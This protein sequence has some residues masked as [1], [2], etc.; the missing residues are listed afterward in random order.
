MY[1]IS[2]DYLTALK[3]Q[4][5][6]Y[7][8]RGT[9]NGTAFDEDDIS[10]LTVSNRCADD[11]EVSI[12]SVYMAEL[13]INFLKS[14]G[15]AWKFSKGWEITIEEGLWI[16]SLEE[17]QYVPGGVYFVEEVQ[18]TKEGIQVTAYDA[19]A[20]FEKSINGLSTQ[21]NLLPSLLEQVC[22]RCGVELANESFEGFPNSST[23]FSLDPE[24]DIENC[25]DLL[26]W[27]AQTMAAY[28]TIN[29]DGE[30]ELRMYK[31]TNDYEDYI[32]ADARADSY[33]FNNYV[34]RYTG[35]M[36]TDREK[37]R[38]K[39]YSEEVDNG[40]T[41][42]LGVNPFMQKLTDQRLQAVCM[43]ILDKMQDIEY[44]PFSI[45]C[46][47]TFAYD[48]GDIINFDDLETANPRIGCIM[49]WDYS[50]NNS[51]RFEGLGSDPAVASAKSKTDKNLS[52]LMS[53]VEASKEYLYSFNNSE[54]ILI[55]EIWHT[56]L[57]QRFGTVSAT[58]ALFHGEILCEALG[59]TVV[60]VRYLLD[61]EIV[62][63]FPVETWKQGKHILTLM[64]PITTN[65]D[66]YY[67]W[68][69]QLRSLSASVQID[70]GNA[71]GIIKGQG[72]VASDVWNGYID[73]DETYTLLN[74][75]DDAEVIRVSDT[76]TASTQVPISG[77][78][79]S[80]SYGLLSTSED[81]SIVDF[82]DGYAFNQDFKNKMTWDESA[83]NNWDYS[84]TFYVWG[85]DVD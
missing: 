42:N 67:N 21:N 76:A 18:T 15:I 53:E 36:V 59:D 82:I 32:D 3:Y 13:R 55:G 37:Q 72:L 79:Y 12:G 48:L 46:L 14:L 8:L 17:Y 39:Y 26:S 34:T 29:R 60:E 6:R 11:G 49:L 33:V 47:P 64:Y 70:A 66:N 78:N 69:V 9:I 65:S 35:I 58:W 74:S 84:E 80:E 57:S 63:R 28:A 44:T 83:L 23:A 73:I 22:N 19:M 20:K 54:D 56:V 75:L 16:E 7:K 40:L 27:I 10:N 51:V 38:T 31:S 71:I 4:V 43:A 5:H 61:N 24:N 50:Y 52:G 85:I 41:Y 45:E 30:L 81:S 1:P 77:G 25:R 2:E 62:Q 68:M